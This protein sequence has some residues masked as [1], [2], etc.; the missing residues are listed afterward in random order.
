MAELRSGDFS[1][2][3]VRQRDAELIRTWR[4]AQLS[5]L[6]QLD[7]LTYEEQQSYFARVVR[8]DF[9]SET[10]DQILF[11]LLEDD[12]LVGYGGLTHIDWRAY[13]AELSFLSSREQTRFYA[14]DLRAFLEMLHTVAFDWLDLARIWHETYGRGPVHNVVL[15]EFGYKQEGTLRDHVRVGGTLRSALI[16]GLLQ[17]ERVEP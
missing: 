1:L 11:S 9:N 10:P 4:N 3:G 12:V 17:S 13:R 16:F 8:R 6:R 2:R 15:E 5:V 7:P 14:E